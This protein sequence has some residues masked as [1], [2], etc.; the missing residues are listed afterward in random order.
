M[1]PAQGDSRSPKTDRSNAQGERRFSWLMILLG[2]A[3]LACG[4]LLY[5]YASG[6]TPKPENTSSDTRNIDRTPPANARGKSQTTPLPAAPS[7]RR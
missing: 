6:N 5:L 7:N 4:L 3:L 1:L 2:I